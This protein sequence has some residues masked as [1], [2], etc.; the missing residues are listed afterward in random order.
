[1]VKQSSTME[2]NK[3]VSDNLLMKLNLSYLNLKIKIDTLFRY[4][5]S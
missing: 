4:N 2:I 1:M 5:F 3:E